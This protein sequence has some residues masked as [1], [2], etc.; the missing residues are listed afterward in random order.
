MRLGMSGQNGSPPYGPGTPGRSCPV[1][2]LL[3]PPQRMVT[4][5]KHTSTRMMLAPNNHW[6]LFSEHTAEPDR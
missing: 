6:A 1:P 3:Q 2:H 4:R 5:Q